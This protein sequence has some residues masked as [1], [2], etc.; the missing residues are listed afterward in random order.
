MDTPKAQATRLRRDFDHLISKLIDDENTA[1]SD[2]ER[3]VPQLQQQICRNEEAIE[4]IQREIEAGRNRIIQLRD[5]LRAATED[6]REVETIFG[7]RS[8]SKGNSTLVPPFPTSPEDAYLDAEVG[9]ATAQ[10]HQETA[11]NVHSSSSAERPTTQPPTA[12]RNVTRSGRPLRESARARQAREPP[13]DQPAPG[14]EKRK[15]DA[16]D[17]SEAGRGGLGRRRGTSINQ[18]G[19]PRKRRHQSG[20]IQFSEA[21]QRGGAKYKHLIVEHPEEPGTWFILLCDEH[22]AHFGEKP[23]LG[24]INHLRSKDHGRVVL[25]IS[26][27]IET[28]GIRVLNCNAARA[29]RNNDA[30]LAAL[31]SG[32]KVLQGRPSDDLGEV[33]HSATATEYGNL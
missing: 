19:D 15:R 20:T 22:S 4:R 23:I 10:P 9:T 8:K 3:E 14:R 32:Y 21:F 28:L 27:A 12:G 33:P 2:Y 18:N 24:A 30:F 7:R 1:R 26:G 17:L 31:K 13:A 5:A 11:E 16:E 25:G 6:R 29:E